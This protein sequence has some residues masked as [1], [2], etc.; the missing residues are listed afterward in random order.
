MTAAATQPPPRPASG[1]GRRCPRWRASGQRVGPTGVE[2]RHCPHRTVVFRR[3]PRPARPCDVL[4]VRVPTLRRREAPARTARVLG[5]PVRA[6]RSTRCP[7][8]SPR[9]PRPGWLRG[10]RCR[11]WCGSWTRCSAGA[12]TRASCIWSPSPAGRRRG[13]TRHR[14]CWPLGRLTH[15][16]GPAPDRPGSRKGP[17]RPPTGGTPHAVCGLYRPVGRVRWINSMPRRSRSCR[18]AWSNCSWRVG[19]RKRPASCPASAAK[20]ARWAR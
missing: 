12:C 5:N 15:A 7:A 17:T 10:R 20:P 19:S 3:W 2:L 8:V 1:P 18:P 16:D 9:P 6:R 11:R 4:C 13:T 14:P